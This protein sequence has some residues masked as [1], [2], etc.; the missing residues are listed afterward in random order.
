MEVR[1]RDGEPV[2]AV[3]FLVSAGILGMLTL[4]VGPL[5]GLAYGVPIA[6]SVLVSAGAT[7]VVCA[8]AFHRL[9]WIAPPA[10]VTVPPEVRFQRLCYLGVVFGL[11]L[12]GLTVPLAV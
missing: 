5:Y 11:V 1:N 10:W 8:V 6:G 3:P 2:D 9:I 7:A 12:L 4:S